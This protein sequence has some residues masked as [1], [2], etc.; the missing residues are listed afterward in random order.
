[1]NRVRVAMPRNQEQGMNARR[2]HR[3]LTYESPEG[4]RYRA[5]LTR[6]RHVRARQQIS[7]RGFDRHTSLP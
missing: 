1:M 7:H 5:A 3:R 6:A 4:A 2:R